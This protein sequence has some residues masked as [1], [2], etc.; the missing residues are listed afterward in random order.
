MSHT[1]CQRP[2][3]TMYVYR[4][5]FPHLRT[6]SWSLTA[7]TCALLC[8][9]ITPVRTVAQADKATPAADKEKSGEK[10]PADK[11]GFP[12]LPPDAH[13]QQTIQLDGKALRYTVTVGALPVR[14]KDG[15][16]A[17]EVVVTA[18]TVEGNN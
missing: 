5:N 9:G 3:P 2:R 18:Y 6:F 14:D 16:I 8:L 7:A 4:M 11:P 10:A 12:P 13:T 15:K 1:G 17:G